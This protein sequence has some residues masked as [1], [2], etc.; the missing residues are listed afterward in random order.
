MMPDPFFLFLALFS[1]L[2]GIEAAEDGGKWSAGYAACFLVA[3]VAAFNN[4]I[5]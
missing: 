2:L 4:R 3:V 5:W 1:L